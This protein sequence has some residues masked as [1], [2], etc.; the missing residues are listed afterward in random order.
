MKKAKPTT[1]TKTKVKTSPKVSTKK[2]N[3]NFT[4]ENGLAF[5]GLFFSVSL[6]ICMLI[7]S[8]TLRQTIPSNQIVKVRGVAEKII[9]A[10][11]ANWRIEIKARDQQLAPAYEKADKAVAYLKKYFE[12]KGID[13]KFISISGYEQREIISYI[14]IDKY[15]NTEARLDGY[16]VSVDVGIKGY[17]KLD[18]IDKLSKKIA[19]DLQRTGWPIKAKNPYYYYSKKV[20]DIKPNLLKEAALNAYQR[21][22]IVAESS[23]SN[24][25]GLKAA[26][27]GVFAGFEGD[28]HVGGNKRKQTVS[29]IVTV[30]YSIER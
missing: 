4:K 19:F 22:T 23:G 10:D 1:K 20:T 7:F 17:K 11:R 29:A 15:K 21:A 30:D 28:G 12:K 9:V 3:F 25:G 18:L 8:K 13:K 26:R 2:I 6:I 14:V 16:T 27:Q 24:L 5:F